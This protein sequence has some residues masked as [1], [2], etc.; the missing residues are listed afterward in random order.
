MHKES[1]DGDRVFVI[2]DFLNDEETAALIARSEASGFSEATITVAGGFQM[3]KEIR[4]NARLIVDDI[5]LAQELW[6]RAQSLSMALVF[7]HL[8]VH[9]GAPIVEG[10]K[11]V[12]RT[13]VMYTTSVKT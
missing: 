5:G 3:N 10:R 6:L 1:L 13:D 4:D 8:Q 12:L 2:H 9:E 11:Y 7:R